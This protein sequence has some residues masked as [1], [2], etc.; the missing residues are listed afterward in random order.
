MGTKSIGTR[1]THGR[2]VTC[3]TFDLLKL[4]KFAKKLGDGEYAVLLV[5]ERA[6]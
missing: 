1:E 6:A 4:T 5:R 3:D 2:A